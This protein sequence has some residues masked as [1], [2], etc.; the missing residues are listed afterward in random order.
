MARLFFGLAV[1][2][3]VVRANATRVIAALKASCT[4]GLYGTGQTIMHCT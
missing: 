4:N 1:E 3:F 2:G